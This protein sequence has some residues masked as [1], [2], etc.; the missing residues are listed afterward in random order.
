MS[1]DEVYQTEGKLVLGDYFRTKCFMQQSCLLPSSQEP[2][3]MRCRRL[4][5]CN[6]KSRVVVSSLGAL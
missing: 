6:L 4:H 3:L 2:K 5:L 1:L